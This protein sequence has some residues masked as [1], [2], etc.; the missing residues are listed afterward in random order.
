M[1]FHQKKEGG[2]GAG[3]GRYL[4]LGQD[5]GLGR[6]SLVEDIYRKIEIVG[7][8]EG[9]VEKSGRKKKRKELK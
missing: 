7:K 2:V 4:N 1:M 5:L 8:R 9:I 3:A 6:E